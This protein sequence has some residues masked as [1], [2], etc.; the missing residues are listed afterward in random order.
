MLYPGVRERQEG[1]TNGHQPGSAQ[2]QA[3]IKHVSQFEDEGRAAMEGTDLEHADELLAF[4]R[5]AQWPKDTPKGVVDFVLNMTNNAVKRQTALLTDARPVMQVMTANLLWKPQAEML[6]KILQ[7]L[8]QEASWLGGELPKGIAMAGLV[9]CNI[10]LARWDPLADAGRGDIRLQFLDPR[11]VV[12]DPIVTRAHR[13]HDGEYVCTRAP[14]SVASL[15]AQYGE[16]ATLVKPDDALS[17]YLSPQPRGITTGLWS[18]ALDTARRFAG[19]RERRRQVEGGVERAL[20]RHAWFWDFERYG[21]EEPMAGQPIYTRPRVMRHVVHAGQRVLVDEVNPLWGQGF[22]HEILDWGMELEHPYGQSEVQQIRKPQEALNSLAS[23]IVANAKANNNFKLVMD[24][25]ALEPADEARLSNKPMLIVRKRVG[26]D[27]RFESPPPLPAYLFTLINWL[28]QAIEMLTGM[29]DVL[30]GGAGGATSGLQLEGMQLAAQT[31][32]RL[33]ARQIEDF[34]QRLWAKAIPLIFQYY[35]SDRVKTILGPG[36]LWSSFV[37]QRYAFVSGMNDPRE[38]FKDFVLKVVPGS[39]LST[40]KLQKTMLAMN[41]H[42][43]G[44]IPGIDVLKQA[45]W[46]PDPE[47]SVAAAKA[48]MV[49]RGLVG[50]GAGGTG[51]STLVG[52]G[53]R[54]SQAFPAA[55]IPVA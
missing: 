17:T 27:V 15:I 28:V 40:T 4:A 34:L 55:G 12:F 16:R 33:Q 50:S 11:S 10:G 53:R 49:E 20:E 14:R 5:G 21:D 19:G 22:P 1:R 32:I 24:W 3:L 6:E 54:A 9:G 25:N 7:A 37:F 48:E 45:E 29:T 39:S 43:A 41:L 31:L 44:L 26:S 46:G 18:V 52:G 36:E 8:W 30:R 42:R 13:L 23:D 47:A 38:A 51:L 35:T 2:E